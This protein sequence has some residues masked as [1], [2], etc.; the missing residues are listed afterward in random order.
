[1]RTF[2][3]AALGA[4]LLAFAAEPFKGKLASCSKGAQRTVKVDGKTIYWNDQGSAWRCV[5]APSGHLVA[6]FASFLFQWGV[7]FWFSDD[8]RGILENANELARGYYDESQRELGL[9]AVAMAGDLRYLLQDWSMTDPRFQE[10][11]SLQLLARQLSQSAILQQAAALQ[12]EGRDHAAQAL[13]LGAYGGIIGDQVDGPLRG[14]H[15]A[16]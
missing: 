11:Y 15:D 3:T 5:K 4:T 10:Q 16:R 12:H 1:M 7:Q 13:V 14:P 9:E 2:R 6:V 8:R